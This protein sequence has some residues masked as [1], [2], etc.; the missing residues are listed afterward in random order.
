M[1]LE[2]SL[3]QDD[4]DFFKVVPFMFE[5]S[6]PNPFIE[7]CWPNGRDAEA[8]KRHAAGFIAH[9]NMDPTVT[10][11]KVTDTETRQIVGVAQWFVFKDNKPPEMDFDGPPGTWK[12]DD[13]KKYAQEVYAL[14]TSHRRQVIREND[15]PIVVLSIMAVHPKHQHRGVGT[16]LMKKGMHMADEMKALSVVDS[17]VAGRPLYDKFDF[18]VKH[19]YYPIPACKSCGRG[20]VLELFFMVR[21]R[22]G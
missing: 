3:L 20:D 11:T 17:T 13:A 1:P 15:V 12:T 21:P 16:M 22:A 5:A 9:K 7:A 14:V 8:Q 6:L 19:H 18:H 2:H 4:A 10:W